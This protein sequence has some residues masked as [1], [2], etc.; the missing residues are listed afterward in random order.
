MSAS[1]ERPPFRVAIVNDYEVVVAGVARMLADHDGRVEVVE[2]D[3]R[4]PVL[5]DVDVV[6]WD[7]FGKGAGD[8]IG[9]RELVAAGEAKV[10]VYTWNRHPEAVEHA[11]GLGAA[12]YLSKAIPGRELMAALEAI[13]DGETVVVPEVRAADA[14]VEVDWPGREAGLTPREAEMLAFLAQGMSNQEAAD[15]TALSINTVK[16]YVRSAYVKIG[17]RRRSQAVAWALKNGFAPESSRDSGPGSVNPAS[18]V[19]PRHGADPGD[20]RGR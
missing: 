10:V 7:T 4:L 14:A 3:S 5:A 16:S 6:L 18:G 8:G 19:P 1:T 15:A 20:D 9:L 2:L 17:A 12:G 13:R 11:L